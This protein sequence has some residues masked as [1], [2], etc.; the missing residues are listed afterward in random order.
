MPHKETSSSITHAALHIRDITDAHRVLEAVRLKILPLVKR[1]LLG[2]ERASLRSGNVF[3]WEESESEDGLVRWTEGRRWSQSKMRGECLY[4]EEQV[5]LTEAERHAKAARRAMK[6]CSIPAPPKRKDRRAKPDGLIKQT[7]SVLVRLPCT[8][9]GIMHKKWHLVSYSSNREAT[10]LPVVEDY[11]YL[12]GIRVP[13]DVFLNSNSTSIR[14]P[15]INGS[16]EPF[17]APLEAPG[18]YIPRSTPVPGH[19]AISYHLSL[20]SSGQQRDST[21]RIVLPAISSTHPPVTL[22]PLSSLGYFLPRGHP[23]NYPPT[24]GANGAYPRHHGRSIY[25]DDRRVLDRFRVVI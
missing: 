16:L 23:G 5:E 14:T 1:R 7:Y 22:P 25:S 11:D 24:V 21:A 3:V 9:K 12:R 15:M 2:H 4:Y 10:T 19:P 13:P 6:G 18:A 17:P 20:S 8:K